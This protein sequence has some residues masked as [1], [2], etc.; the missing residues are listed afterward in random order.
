MEAL[1]ANDARRSIRRRDD[2]RTGHFR[3]ASVGLMPDRRGRRALPPTRREH[4]RVVIGAVVILL[5][6]L[7]VGEV[8]D[9]VVKSSPGVGRRTNETWVAAVAALVD[10]SNTLSP[11]L[12]DVRAHATDPAAFDRVTLQFALAEL[13]RGV[14]SEATM[15]RTLGL[16]APSSSAGVLAF[17]VLNLRHE[18]IESLRVASGSQSPARPGDHRS[19][20]RRGLL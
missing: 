13:E 5:V 20:G 10:E 6:C 9:Q 18:G 1:S 12:R 14:A 16:A 3:T 4:W 7:V 11:M 17:A 15:Y 2:S 8:V 19:R